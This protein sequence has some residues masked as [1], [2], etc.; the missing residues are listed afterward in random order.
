MPAGH[1]KRMAVLL[2]KHNWLRQRQPA[3]S[4][5]ATEE[6]GGRD[7]REW[8]GG[9]AKE[10]WLHSQW[11]LATFCQSVCSQLCFL[12]HRNLMTFPLSSFQTSSATFHPPHSQVL[13]SLSIAVQLFPTRI[14]SLPLT[15]HS[16]NRKSS[17]KFPHSLLLLLPLLSTPPVALP[18]SCWPGEQLTKSKSW[19]P[20]FWPW[21]QHRLCHSPLPASF[22]LWPLALAPLFAAPAQTWRCLS[23]SDPALPGS[24][25]FPL[26]SPSISFWSW[27]AP[28]LLLY[29]FP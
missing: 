29:V 12:S 19:G 6:D 13:S 22:L 4:T 21:I 9:P 28:F 14:L 17:L 23:A 20:W 1:L 25:L 15:F 24:G 26:A 3:N 27:K 16:P 18:S 10:E 7:W 2:W 11:A 5:V 8:A